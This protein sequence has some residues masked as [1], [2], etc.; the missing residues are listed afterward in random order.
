[1]KKLL[2]YTLTLYSIFGFSQKS[3][4]ELLKKYNTKSVPYISVQ[5][6]ATS[7]TE[8]IL[9]DSRELIEYK[10]SHLKNAFYVGYDNFNEE[11]IQQKIP[12]KNAKIVVYCS[13]GIRSEDIAEKLKNIGYMNVFNLYGGIFK[14]KNNNLKVYDFKE[15]ET[16]KV[17]TFNKQ[18]SKWLLKGTKVYKK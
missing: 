9:L 17:H 5:E 8:F 6:L 11:I 2:F 16:E 4:S 3:I 13:V 18:W 1:M 10:T 15:N 7:K 12:N 14:W